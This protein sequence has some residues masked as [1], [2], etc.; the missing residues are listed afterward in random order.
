MGQQCVN[1]PWQETNPKNY[2]PTLG[3]PQTD[4]GRISGWTT[5]QGHDLPG[6]GR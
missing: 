4:S 5:G 6:G 1:T 2:K 3:L